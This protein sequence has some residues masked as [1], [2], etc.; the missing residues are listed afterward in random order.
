MASENRPNASPLRLQDGPSSPMPNG[1]RQSILFSQLLNSD[2]KQSTM[3]I[4]VGSRPAYTPST[5]RAPEPMNEAEL[6]AA[7]TSSSVP[8][9]ALLNEV[10][11][12]RRDLKL[13]DEK[14]RVAVAAM[15]KKQKEIESNEAEIA[16]LVLEALD[17]IFSAFFKKKICSSET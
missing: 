6:T 10:L 15:E 11:E 12:A 2:P 17:D 3:E 13:N 1:P 8:I 9:N 5:P 16:A 14:V 4:L 7:Q